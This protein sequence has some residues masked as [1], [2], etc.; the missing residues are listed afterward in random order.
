MKMSCKMKIGIVGAGPAGLYFALLMKRANPKLAIR[1][2]DQ[3]ACGT[4]YGWG[5]VFSGRACA[6]LA[7]A[8]PPSY[9]DIAAQLRSWE[10]QHICHRGQIVPID[11][12]HFSGI[13][14]AALLGILQQHCLAEGVDIAFETP[15]ADLRIFADQDLIVGADGVHSL[16][17]SLHAAAFQPTVT[18]VSNKYVWYGTS[19]L[20]SA[21]SLIFRANADGCFVAHAYPYSEATSTFIVECDAHTWQAAGFAAM[22]DAESR[23]YCERLFAADLDGHTL[24]SNR[25][26][27]THFDVISNCRWHH[28]N[29]VLLGDALRTVHFSIGSGTRTA[30]Q[31]AI[32]LFEAFQRHGSDIAAAFRSFEAQRR[33][34]SEQLARIAQQSYRW[35]ERFAD[36]MAL[37]PLELAYR[38]MTRG[39]LSDEKLAQQTPGFMRA[40]RQ[41]LV[42]L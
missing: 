24:L 21:L 12:S 23:A 6:L 27:W 14:R 13:S 5:I 1:V 22:T 40:Y 41:A 33:P 11:G 26:D 25:S 16:V 7:Q 2:M 37:A 39:G 8:D 19:R 28:Q 20:F 4:A 29:I 32:V 30:L 35:Y 9:H 34:A 10:T 38:Y 15:L 18:P 17:R 42:A 3:R 36:E 31:D